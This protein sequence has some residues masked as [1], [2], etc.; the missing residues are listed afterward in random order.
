MLLPNDN[1]KSRSPVQQEASSPESESSPPVFDTHAQAKN[2]GTQTPWQS[3]GEQQALFRYLLDQINDGIFII[4]PDSG[5]ILDANRAAYH[6]LGYVREDLVGAHLSTITVNTGKNMSLS[7]LA[8]KGLTTSG[9]IYE[10]Y[11]QHRNGHRIPM[12]I[13]ARLIEL[14]SRSYIVAIARDITDRKQLENELRQLTTEDS[15]TGVFNRR[16]FDETLAQ[17]W[18]R[19]MRARHPIS[20]LMVDVDHFKHYNDTYGHIGGDVCLRQIAVEMKRQMRRAGDIVARYG[21][22][23]FVVILPETDSETALAFAE[24]LRQSI[25][26]LGLEHIGLVDES[27]V[28][29]SIGVATAVPEANHSPLRLVG[30]ADKALYRAKADGRNRVHLSPVGQVPPNN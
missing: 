3:I 2:V 11:H 7:Q 14:D 8:K 28:T 16:F 15:L 17:E 23:E 21:G 18:R 25:E 4:D 30:L 6:R 13:N 26:S 24:T 1:P 29:I 10:E 12:E 22:E 5:V 20:L 9:G 19:M 27:V